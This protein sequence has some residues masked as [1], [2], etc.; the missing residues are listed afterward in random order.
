MNR[1]KGILMGT[2]IVPLVL[3]ILAVVM[4][5]LLISPGQMEAQGA[6][7]YN[8]QYIAASKTTGKFLG[9]VSNNNALTDGEVV[10]ITAINESVP[11]PRPTSDILT[12]DI[13]VNNSAGV[14]QYTVSWG[15]TYEGTSVVFS[16]DVTL[17]K[18][19]STD[20]SL[21]ASGITLR[22]ADGYN[23]TFRKKGTTDKPLLH[24]RVDLGGPS[25]SPVEPGDTIAAY[26]DKTYAK[27]G[28]KMNIRISDLA[29]TQQWFIDNS[30]A[31]YRWNSGSWNVWDGSQISL[32]TSLGEHTLNVNATDP[33]GQFTNW[34]KAYNVTFFLTE[35]ELQDNLTLSKRTIFIST[36]EIKSPLKLILRD[37]DLVFLDSNDKLVV[38]NGASFSLFNVSVGS[39][40]DPYT[41]YSEV[42][43][44]FKINAST[45]N[46]SDYS[47][48]HTSIL[49]LGSGWI[50]NT[51]FNN[52]NNRISINGAGVEL[53]HSRI[54]LAGTG[55]IYSDLQHRWSPSQTKIMNNTIT[56]SSTIPLQ[57]M[58][59]SIGDP[60]DIPY[61]YYAEDGNEFALYLVNISGLTDPYFKI[62]YFLDS[63]DADGEFE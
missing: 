18:D 5:A 63:R 34:T 45:I 22:V 58:N 25:I 33:Y 16:G 49:D 36:M 24:F 10:N 35:P 44:D 51:T 53:L 32:P 21:T 52:I 11:S 30:K 62:P 17:D 57:I 14:N 23:I 26:G 1:N 41:I 9:P 48:P 3:G 55:G 15:L 19:L 59:S 47:L 29:A 60:Y 12:L 42:G 13:L 28:G 2:P 43:A 56:G 6:E 20:Y 39:L 46:G 27:S 38:N 40:G 50:Y 37:S 54:D 61:S 4:I 8:V 7:F 31:K